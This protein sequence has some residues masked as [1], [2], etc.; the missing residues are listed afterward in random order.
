VREADTDIA[1]RGDDRRA[2]VAELHAQRLNSAHSRGRAVLEE[3]L[4]VVELYPLLV[5]DGPV[6][7]EDYLEAVAG[8]PQR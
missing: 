8:L 6:S 4:G 7:R 3:A 2:L 1:R 5:S